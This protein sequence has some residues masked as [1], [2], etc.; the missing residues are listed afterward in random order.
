MLELYKFF[1]KEVASYDLPK[2]YFTISII[3][4]I[5]LIIII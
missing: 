3:L 2:T 4:K 1:F 5:E